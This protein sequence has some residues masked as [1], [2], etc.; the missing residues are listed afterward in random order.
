MRPPE[1]ALDGTGAD[2]AAA[3]RERYDVLAMT[4]LATR[5]LEKAG[6]SSV[7]AAA[8]AETF[9]EADLMGF[10][11]H[12]LQRIPSNLQWLLDGS[13]RCD[14]EIEV[15][16]D[17][18]G[19]LVW[20]AAN[21]P[22]P[23][24]VRE[25]VKE[26]VARSETNGISAIAIRRT[27]HIACLATYLRPATDRDK[28]ILIV[29]STPAESVVSAHGGL[30]P[31]FSCNPLAVGIPTEGAP[32]LIDTS[33]SMSAL[34]PLYRAQR[35]GRRLPTRCI[36]TADGRL[37]DDPAEFVDRPGASILPAG[38]DAQGYKGFA[39][40][41]MSEALT[42]ALSGYGRTDVTQGD[43]AN[44]VYV[45]VIDPDKFTGRRAFLHEMAGLAAA[46]QRSD[47]LPNAGPVRL[48]GERA[49]ASR[50]EQLTHGLRLHPLVVEDLKPWVARFGMTFP[51]PLA[52]RAADS[53]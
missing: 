30:T 11:T 27:Q 31:I 52:P 16:T 26:A 47:A 39:L 44:A 8:M 36:R 53:G 24:V 48:P 15:I 10:T 13:T 23:W 51:E 29:A 22:G 18:G 9:V 4:K 14:G 21:L 50:K 40:L 35:E 12:G 7:R 32:I 41:L 1:E 6:L 37:T 46:C 45:Q 34:G 20:G 49:L 28:M 38:G 25:A 43:E 3:R 19:T 42:A 5:L 2:S 33:L 17:A